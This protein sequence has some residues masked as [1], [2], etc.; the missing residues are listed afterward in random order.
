M[1]TAVI[2]E[3]GTGFTKQYAEWISEELGCECEELK[4]F[5]NNLSDYDMAI[6]GG[7][8]FA[9]KI[10]DLDK[11]QQLNPKTYIVFAVG[12]TEDTGNYADELKKANPL[13]K[14]TLFYLRGGARFSKLGFMNRTILKKVTKM[15]ED[16]DYSDKASIAKLVDFVK[17]RE[18]MKDYKKK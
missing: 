12:M 5:S 17:K 6:Y 4:S 9:G 11:F 7:S 3:S 16:V 13:D 18:K 8:I 1:K 15:K 10:R 14:V 2:Y